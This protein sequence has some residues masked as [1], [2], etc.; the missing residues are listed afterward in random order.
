MAKVF[1]VNNS[2]HDYTKAES[3]GELVMCSAGSVNKTDIHQMYRDMLSALK[4]AQ[5]EDYLL[6]S[7]LCSLCC[8]ATAIFA[9]RFGRVNFLI[10]D[11]E[12]YIAK[13][14]MLE[15]YYNFDKDL[16]Q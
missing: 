3:F 1:I 2:G 10:W 4:D 9:D 6:I 8:V 15:S 12:E 14:L 11:R 7:S 5:P 13:N 16:E